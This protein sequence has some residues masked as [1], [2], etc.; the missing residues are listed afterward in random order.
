LAITFY[1]IS[2]Q[3]FKGFGYL[4]AVTFLPTDDKYMYV[5]KGWAIKLAPAPR[6]STI[7]VDKYSSP[8]DCTFFVNQMLFC[9]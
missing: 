6:P 1:L 5:C 3:M 9:P 2:N 4:N 7:Y 8:A